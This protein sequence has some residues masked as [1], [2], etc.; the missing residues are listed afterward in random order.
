MQTTE[1]QPT[2]NTRHGTDTNKANIKK[3]A[4]YRK[5]EH[6]RLYRNISFDFLIHK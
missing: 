1:A 2:L 5:D 4:Q 3:K 6:H